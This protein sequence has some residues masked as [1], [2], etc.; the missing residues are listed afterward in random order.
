MND[1]GLSKAVI[2]ARGLGTRMRAGA[3]A[4]LTAAQAAAADVGIKAMMPVGRPF[5][6]YVL[7]A[8]ADAGLRRV[9]LVIGP[10]H[11]AV[12]RYYRELSPTRLTVEFAVQ[13]EPRGTADAVLAAEDFVAGDSFLCLNGDNYYPAAALRALRTLDECGMVAFDREGLIA[14]GNIDPQRV[15]RFAVVRTDDAGYLVD[16]VEKP[17]PGFMAALAGS[18]A[19]SMNCWRFDTSIFPACRAIEPSQRG[20]LEI[21]D[22]VALLI[23]SPDRPRRFRAVPLSAPVLDLSSRADIAAVAARLAHVEVSL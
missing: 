15:S 3:E 14:G 8:L 11:E 22:A 16:I 19:V 23:H 13:A 18:V 20:E 10:Q 2:L 6:D 21:P 1:V 4:D 5:L 7:A 12:R 17:D 9:C